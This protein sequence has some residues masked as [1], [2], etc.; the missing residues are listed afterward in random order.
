M[1]IILFLILAI[2]VIHVEIYERRLK[3]RLK[4]ELDKEMMEENKRL[5]SMQKETYEKLWK[6][7][8]EKLAKKENNK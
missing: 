6:E 1:I 4:Q 8:K 2:P 3:K 7:Y 5:Y